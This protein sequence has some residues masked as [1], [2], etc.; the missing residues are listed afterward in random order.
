MIVS[1]HQP[2][3][4]P[5]LGYF[6]KINQADLFIYL[7]TVQFQKGSYQNRNKVLTRNGPVWLTVP[8][9]TS[10]CLYTTA[11]KDLTID[12]RQAWQ[13]KHLSTLRLNYSGAQMYKEVFPVV[14]PFYHKPWARLS[15]LCW[16]MLL[17]FNELLGIT[18][19][20]IKASEIA[21]VEGKKS[22]LILNL[23]RAV[24]ATTYLSGS[25]GKDYLD[26]E[27]FAAANVKVLFQNYVPATYRQQSDEFV[28]ALG[29][30][31]LLFNEAQPRRLVGRS[32]ERGAGLLATGTHNAN[33]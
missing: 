12:N 32:N 5:W 14:E 8:V 2:A 19:P 13:A 4:L 21:G 23:C 9:E 28:A 20:V 26:L 29:V 22:D 3:Y 17:K 27:K 30:V 24:K 25:Q 6:D 31:D 1:I 16:E 11:L 7:D 10:G 15:D 18:T 33:R